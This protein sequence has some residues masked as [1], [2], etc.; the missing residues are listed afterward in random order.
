MKEFFHS[1]VFKLLVALAVVMFAFMLRATMTMGAATVLEKVV[2]TVTAPLQS[3]SASISGSVTGFLDQ[4]LN[5]EEISAENER[6][7]E[8]NR[9][10][11]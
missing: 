6:L 2:G 4:F 9:A 10:L 7:R 11:I 5:A 8:E 1:W 3:A